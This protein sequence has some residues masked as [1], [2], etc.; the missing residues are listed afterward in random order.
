LNFILGRGSCVRNEL[1]SLLIEYIV[2]CFLILNSV[3]KQIQ[4]L[5]GK[6]GRIGA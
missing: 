1:F 4:S 3:L 6:I 5:M 2:T